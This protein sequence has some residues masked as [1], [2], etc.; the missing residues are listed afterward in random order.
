M[1]MIQLDHVS[2]AFGE[3]IVLKDISL[4]LEAGKIHGL[5]G[6]N[7]CG[8]SVLLKCICGLMSCDRGSI[9]VNGKKVSVGG[10]EQ[11]FIGSIIEHTGF[12]GSMSGYENLRYLAG[13][14]GKMKR[15]QIMQALQNVNLERDAKT[16]V[17]KYSL[18]MRQRLAI[19]QAIMENP[20]VYIL[21][22]PFNALDQITTKHMHDLFLRIKS[23][24]KTFLLVSH[25]QSDIDELCDD[26]FEMKGGNVV[27]KEL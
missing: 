14:R 19:A 2:K 13:I 1:D 23:E 24:G 7:G 27:A 25:H 12:I 26:V 5:I 6:D 17:Q 21:D 10:H 8:K 18:G 9:T 3:K 22:E 11:P 15:E 4:Q 20:D 16:Q